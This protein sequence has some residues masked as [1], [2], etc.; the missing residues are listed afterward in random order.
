[1]RE[2]LTQNPDIAADI[3][4]KVRGNAAKIAEELLVSPNKDH[5][6]DDAGP[7]E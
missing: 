3:E 6:E 4:K 2:F 7:D 1:M 5:V